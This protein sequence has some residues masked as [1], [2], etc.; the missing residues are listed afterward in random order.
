MPDLAGGLFGSA[1]ATANNPLLISARVGDDGAAAGMIDLSDN[2]YFPSTSS[3]PG[4]SNGLFDASSAAPLVHRSHVYA[5][6]NTGGSSAGGLHHYYR[7]HLPMRNSGEIPAVGGTRNYFNPHRPYDF[8][9]NHHHRNIWLLETLNY[10]ISA[11][12]QQNRSG[13][14]DVSGSNSSLAARYIDK[15]WMISAFGFL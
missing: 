14:G 12:M 9:R 13:V 5:Q 7:H 4:D 15:G 3:Y 1:G 8:P 6:P 2:M 11:G 10:I